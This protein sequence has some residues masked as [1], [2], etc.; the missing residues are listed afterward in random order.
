MALARARRDRGV[1]YWPGFVDAL[2]TLVLGIVF[3]LSVFVVMQF[4][5]SQE[6]TGKDIALARLN[7]QIAQLTELLSLEKTGKT[8]LEETLATLRAGLATALGEA[9][10]AAID[11]IFEFLHLTP[12]GQGK[13][14]P[15]Y[16][17]AS[18]AGACRVAKERF[19]PFTRTF[20]FMSHLPIVIHAP[21]AHR[22]LWK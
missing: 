13:P 18:H 19:F 9:R 22:S 16:G 1:E 2:S 6:V 7:S 21:V 11:P 17:T 10:D 12:I 5:L 20:R 3:L 4:F 14:C 8:T 15:Y